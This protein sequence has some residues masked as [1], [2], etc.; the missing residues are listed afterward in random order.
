MNSIHTNKVTTPLQLLLL[1]I[2]TAHD[3]EVETLWNRWK[4]RV[5]DPMRVEAAS[6]KLFPKIFS[7]VSHSASLDTF[8]PILK[9][10]YRFHWARNSLL[11]T[12]AAEISILL[13][14]E[15]IPHFFYKGIA[16]LQTI[17]EADVGIRPMEDID[18]LISPNQMK[19]TI[20]LLQKSRWIVCTPY[21]ES[22]YSPLFTHEITLKRNSTYLDLHCAVWG[23]IPT[24]QNSAFRFLTSSAVSEQGILPVLLPTDQLFILL[25]QGIEETP[26]THLLWI[27]DSLQLI[28]TSDIDW[29]RLSESS[30]LFGVGLQITASLQILH[31]HFVTSIPAS[32]LAQV[33][34]LPSSKMNTYRFHLCREPRSGYGAFLDIVGAFWSVYWMQAEGK[35]VCQMVSLMRTY[36][37]SLFPESTE[38]ILKVSLKHLVK[39]IRRTI[40]NV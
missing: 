32:I 11:K 3:G 39:L 28:E 29:N 23:G 16:L 18:I 20:R 14:T 27:L 36:A 19:K 1:T 33:K 24:S 13:K 9:S 12:M 38:S 40:S 30:Q 6:L 31:S 17:Y 2:C 7:K 21:N 4:F 15:H 10:S 25:K 34:K 5:G 37:Y 35:S 26:T 8:G 22:R